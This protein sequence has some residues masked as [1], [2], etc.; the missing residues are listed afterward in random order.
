MPP[1]RCSVA[2]FFVKH[3]SPIAC[4]IRA[5]RV[6]D[7][8]RDGA[9][10]DRTRIAMP[11][12]MPEP[13]SVVSTGRNR[14][15]SIARRQQVV[16]GDPDRLVLGRDDRGAEPLGRGHREPWVTPSVHEHGTWARSRPRSSFTSGTVLADAGVVG[17]LELDVAADERVGQARGE[18]RPVL[19]QAD[20]V[21]VGLDAFVDVLRSGTP[22]GMYLARGPPCRRAG[23]RRA[24]ARQRVLELLDARRQVAGATV[25]ERQT[26][27]RCRCRWSRLRSRRS[28]SPWHR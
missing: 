3:M 13:M 11:G 6:A 24:Q 7:V 23:R 2:R 28:R 20:D 27:R 21:L 8:V 25:G 26:R 19:D 15:P 9:V 17:C 5:H 18:R 22:S 4:G 16:E 12:P 14:S 1:W 10:V